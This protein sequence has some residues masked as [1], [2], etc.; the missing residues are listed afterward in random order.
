MFYSR[1][2]LTW[3]ENLAL[4]VTGVSIL[5]GLFV[6]ANAIWYFVSGPP[7]SATENAYTP[8]AEKVRITDIETISKANLFGVAGATTTTQEVIQNTNLRL[9]LHGSFVSDDPASSIALIS[10]Q[11]QRNPESYGIGDTV[12]G[13]ARLEEIR[14]DRVI[15]SRGGN[16]EQLLYHPDGPSIWP[17]PEEKVA[18][19]SSQSTVNAIS[20]DNSIPRA[21]NKINTAISE[22]FTHMKQAREGDDLVFGDEI[23][24][25]NLQR[26]GLEPGDR[27]V[28]INSLSISTL[29]DDEN[30]AE[31]LGDTDFL[32]M[33]VKRGQRTF[34]LEIPVGQ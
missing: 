30:F 17:S 21:D 16:R 9:K 12:S 19:L 6:L 18:S 26:Y 32:K 5:I 27:I 15:L 2:L 23:E 10:T 14:Q 29:L 33:E 25:D 8:P 28:S 4:P 20:E 31:S 24:D 1:K 34:A 3:L 22:L 13:I 7:V 11:S